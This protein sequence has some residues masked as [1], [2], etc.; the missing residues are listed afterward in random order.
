MTFEN[1]SEKDNIAAGEYKY[2][3]M[4]KSDYHQQEI[5][6]LRK[7]KTELEKLLPLSQGQVF[8]SAVEELNVIKVILMAID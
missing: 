5:Y 6:D 2:L 4:I 1:Q 8:I 3:S 7:R